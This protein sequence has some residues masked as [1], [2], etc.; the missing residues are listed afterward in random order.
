M[1]QYLESAADAFKQAD[2]QLAQALNK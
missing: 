1:G 2:E